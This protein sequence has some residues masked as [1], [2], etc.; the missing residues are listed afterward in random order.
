MARKKQTVTRNSNLETSEKKE[1]EKFG[2]KKNE[3]DFQNNQLD[4]R[5]FK[6]SK[7]TSKF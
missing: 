2:F 5:E 4:K 1:S 3:M 7:E 6:K